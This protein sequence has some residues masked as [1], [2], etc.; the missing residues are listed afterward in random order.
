MREAAVEES[1]FFHGF[2]NTKK[3]EGHWNKS[4]H[5]F[6]SRLISQGICNYY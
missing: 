6:A 3:G 4:G 1:I 2:D 5:E